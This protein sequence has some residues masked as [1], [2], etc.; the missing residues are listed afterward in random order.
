MESIRHELENVD[1]TTKDTNTTVKALPDNT[2][3]INSIKS[4]GESTSTKVTE[5]ENDVS[6]I[7]DK[8]L[9]IKGDVKE[10]YKHLAAGLNVPGLAPKNLPS[11]IQ[12]T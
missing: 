3:N 4:T 11:E 7:K 8:T 1:T 2:A 10:S 12:P 6:D 5:V 9:I